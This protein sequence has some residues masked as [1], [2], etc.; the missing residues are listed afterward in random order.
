MY[1][2]R[3]WTQTKGVGRREARVQHLQERQQHLPTT[4]CLAYTRVP[5]Q[6]EGAGHFRATRLQRIDPSIVSRP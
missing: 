4:E 6:A 2:A 5:W 3:E 1:H